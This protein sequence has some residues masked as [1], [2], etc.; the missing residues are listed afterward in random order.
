MA[1][2]SYKKGDWQFVHEYGEVFIDLLKD[3]DI[4]L[5]TNK[6]FMLGPWLESAKNLA[7]T[8]DEKV[9]YEFNARNQITLWG[10]DGQILDYAG[11]FNCP[12]LLNIPQIGQK[13]IF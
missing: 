11:N 9:N 6:N 13:Y 10:P 3:L 12:V 7:T 8:F 4:I 5:Q 1:I 2:D